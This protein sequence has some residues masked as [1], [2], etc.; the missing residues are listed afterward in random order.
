MLTLKDRHVPNLIGFHRLFDPIFR[1]R[2]DTEEDLMATHPD[3][4]STA[5]SEAEARDIGSLYGPFSSHLDKARGIVGLIRRG[6]K[7][8]DAGNAASAAYE[9]IEAAEKLAE[10][11]YRLSARREIAKGHRE[12]QASIVS[13]GHVGKGNGGEPSESSAFAP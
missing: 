13:G 12:T 6:L 7:E 11:M 10:Q 1:P 8:D 3:S 2:R 9:H 4:I 5:L